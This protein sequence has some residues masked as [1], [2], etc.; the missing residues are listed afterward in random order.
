MTA[1][2]SS[3]FLSFSSPSPRRCGKSPISQLLFAVETF[4]DAY[5]MD[6]LAI[7]KQHGIPCSL[8]MVM[9]TMSHDWNRYEALEKGYCMVILRDRHDTRE[10]LTL[11][12]MMFVRNDFYRT[13]IMKLLYV[14]ACVGT[15][16]EM[17]TDDHFR[18]NAIDIIARE[19]GAECGEEQ[20]VAALQTFRDETE[21]ERA[22]KSMT[23]HGCRLPSQEILIDLRDRRMDA[24]QMWR[25]RC[26][27]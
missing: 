18:A 2:T 4:H 6:A 16:A 1:T 8:E 9:A 5:I 13:R 17:Y 3:S 25:Q 20:C 24:R 22:V 23:E 19:R 11:R 27:N 21:A 26:F 14:P 12:V 10:A 7:Q 15:V